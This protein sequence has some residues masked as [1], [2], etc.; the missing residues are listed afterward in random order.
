M[1]YREIKDKLKDRG[2]WIVRAE[3]DGLVFDEII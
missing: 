1:C 3:V 2:R